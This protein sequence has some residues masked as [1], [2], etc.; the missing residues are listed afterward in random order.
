MFGISTFIEHLSDVLNAYIILYC[1][2]RLSLPLYHQIFQRTFHQQNTNDNVI[3][4]LYLFYQA[5]NNLV[6]MM[7]NLYIQYQPL[8]VVLVIGAWNYPVQLTLGPMIGA[9]AA[10]K[11]LISINYLRYLDPLM[12]GQYIVLNILLRSTFYHVCSLILVIKVGISI[13]KGECCIR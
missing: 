5:K 1:R 3:W 13:S 7:D 11:L 2:Y 8:G 4:F 6:T 10:G 12:L 9:I